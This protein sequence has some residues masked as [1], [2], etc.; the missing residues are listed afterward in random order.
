MKGADNPGIAHK[1]TSALA[2]HGLSIQKLET[3]QEIAPYGGSVL[4][5]MRGVAQ[6]AAPLAQS[7]N[8]EQIRKELQELGDD[9]NCEVELEA[10][11]EEAYEAKFYSG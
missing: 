9:L 11:S 3:D 7:F 1:L 2:A 10:A 8:E 6:A 5:C 4:F